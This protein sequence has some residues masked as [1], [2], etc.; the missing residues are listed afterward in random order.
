MIPVFFHCGHCGV[1][2]GVGIVVVVVVV[3]GGGGG[4]GGGVC[5]CQGSEVGVMGGWGSTLIEAGGVEWDGWF[6]YFA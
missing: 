6:I 2:I 4:G 5:E 3:V 1:F